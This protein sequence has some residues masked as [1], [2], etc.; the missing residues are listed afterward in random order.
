M[1]PDETCREVLNDPDPRDYAV[2]LA[3]EGL[4]DPACLWH[5]YD[6]HRVMAPAEAWLHA[7]RHFDDLDPR[8]DPG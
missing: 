1:T 4:V 6:Q 8:Y 2:F 7:A 3:A 5:L